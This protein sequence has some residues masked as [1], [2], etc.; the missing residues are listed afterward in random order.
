MRESQPLDLFWVKGDQQIFEDGL[1]LALSYWSLE[2]KLEQSTVGS[3]ARIDLQ[4]PWIL[5]DLE[6]ILPPTLLLYQ[7]VI[8]ECPEPET[9]EESPDQWQAAGFFVRQ[10]R[11][12]DWSERS[13]QDGDCWCDYSFVK[14]DALDSL[15]DIVGEG[16]STGEIIFVPKF[17]PYWDDPDIEE[18]IDHEGNKH[19]EWRTK[20]ANPYEVEV[21]FR[22]FNAVWPKL[23]S[24][25]TIPIGESVV[26]DSFL[27][28]V[29][30]GITPKNMLRLRRDEMDAFLRWHEYVQPLLNRP[31]VS[32]R[33][34]G[35]AIE[36]GIADLETRLRS[37]KTKGR[38]DMLGTVLATVPAGVALIGAESTTTIVG[39][40]CTMGALACRSLKTIYERYEGKKSISQSKHYFTWLVNR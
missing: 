33:E 20:P 26:D 34:L 4:S 19:L 8:V 29:L 1:R 10:Y 2:H 35:Q 25:P 36:A 39:T 40:I 6:D 11:C 16:L 32:P 37:L 13:R 21:M 17:R 12:A 5:S 22:P 15:K 9:I 31:S 14:L 28:P 24:Y 3:V 18:W 7:N 30:K 27:L 23:Y 38:L